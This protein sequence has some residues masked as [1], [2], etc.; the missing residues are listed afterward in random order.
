[1]AC[2]SIT[3]EE[4][5]VERIART[6]GTMTADLLALSGWLQK[7]RITRVAMESTGVYGWPVCTVLEDEERTPLVVNPQH[8]KAYPGHKTAVK[9]SEWIAAL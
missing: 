6:F 4:G 9:E 3:A 2:V 7:R 5:G 1:V 8:L